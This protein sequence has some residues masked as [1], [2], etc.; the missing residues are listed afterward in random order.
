M[1]IFVG[2]VMLIAALAYIEA[3]C[4]PVVAV[5]KIV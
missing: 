2:F 5:I 4:P 3:A 1:K